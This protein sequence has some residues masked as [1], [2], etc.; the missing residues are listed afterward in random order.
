MDGTA[1]KNYIIK[2]M[3]DSNSVKILEL[4]KK[5]KVT[6]ETI[7]HDLYDLEKEKLVK[8]VRGGAILNT[9]ITE[10]PYD[11]RLDA[12]ISE[13]SDIADK[14]VEYIEKGDTIYLDYGTTSLF[15]ARKI[16]NMNNINVVTNSLPIINE[17][18]KSK[19]VRLI[20]LGGEVRS[21]EGSLYGREAINNL[22]YLN[23]NIGFFSGSGF[24]PEFGLS[25][26]HIGE[27]EL[28][29]VVAEH[30]QSIIVG[31]DHYKFGNVFINKVLPVSK[32]D[33]LITDS[34]TDQELIGRLSEETNL[35]FAQE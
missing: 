30:S 7:R 6:R 5:L 26:I 12:H 29:R 9:P 1:R 3:K 8:V 34:L 16:K 17:L 10:T 32:I 2:M 21:N 19:S 4:S 35:V 15:V 33:T 11:K 28:A 20:V 18:Y 14:F 23:I 27:S 22:K 24:S 13:K 25:N 31:I